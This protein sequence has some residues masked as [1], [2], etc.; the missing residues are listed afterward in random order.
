MNRWTSRI[1]TFASLAGAVAL[2][3][4]GVARA[5][6]AATSSQPSPKHGHR[7]G[8]I[9]DALALGSLTPEQRTA[10][11]QLA[12]TRHTAE[13]PVRHA[14]A[15]VLTVLAQQ[16]E[17]ASINR[18]AL[19]PSVQVRDSA[20]AAAHTVQLDTLQKL[21]D[22]L[23]PAQRGQLVDAVEGQ[24]RGHGGE[25]RRGHLAEVAKELGL[26]DQQ[27]Q[28]IAS[29]LHA[30]WAAQ[31]DA[32]RHGDHRGAGKAWLEA[33]RGDAFNANASGA[34]PNFERRADRMEDLFA[35][36]VPVLSPAQRA[37]LATHLRARAAHESQT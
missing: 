5:Q 4:A 24:S 14:D 25:G 11:E 8:L 20:A 33:F 16:V 9:E 3:P 32:G 7:M 18:Q 22:L 36:A 37:Q 30:E 13:I 21:H 19:A 34:N 28:Q 6:Q 2:V 29:N 17:Q 31:G 26:T 23:T 12:Q 10:I 35:A 27:K 15:Q 1:I